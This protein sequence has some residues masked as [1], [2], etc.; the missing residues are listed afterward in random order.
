MMMRHRDFKRTG[1]DGF[2]LLEL[3]I[4]LVLGLIVMS[5]LIWL[6][7]SN[8]QAALF[9]T[10][11]LRVQ[12]N[13]R[14]AIDMISRSARMIGYDDPTTATT[15]TSP[16]VSGTDGS[17]ST[18]LTVSNLKPFADTLVVRYEGGTDIR[19]CRGTE[20]AA[21]N[22]VTNFY[23]V[24]TD[25]NLVCATANGNELTLAEGVEDVQI[26]YGE[27]VSGDGIANRYVSAASVTSWNNIVTVQVALLVNSVATAL[28]A[29]FDSDGNPDGVCIGCTLFAT[30]NDQLIRGEFI[31]TINIRN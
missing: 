31:T 8:T 5:I 24:T 17:G 23:A 18:L 21:E 28:P 13:G 29:L 6:Y 22:E 27:D 15:L 12:E 2:T 25:N 14:F 16:V 19:D 26:L 9:Q 20:V 7:L 11:V 1:A 4:A 30:V 3:L 10:G